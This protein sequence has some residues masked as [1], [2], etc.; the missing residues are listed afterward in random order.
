M[1]GTTTV[2]S[3][4]QAKYNAASK[5]S[6]PWESY[7]ANNLP[8]YTVPLAIFLRRAREL[9]YRKESS[10]HLVQRV[11]RVYSPAV[12]QAMGKHPPPFDVPPGDLASLQGDM[13]SLLEEIYAQHAKKV[14]ELDVFEWF[15]A[16]L[17]GL[18]GQGVVSG[19][20]KALQALVERARV[21]VNWP[22]DFQIAAPKRTKTA[23]KPLH[24]S[25]PE[26]N[27]D[28]TLT[29][30]GRRDMLEGRVKCT[31]E[32]VR[33]Q[34]DP[35]RARVRTYE[36]SLLVYVT[37]WL[38]ERLRERFGFPVNLRFLADYRNLGFLVVVYWFL[39]LVL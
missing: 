21:M 10:I 3:L 18:F 20:E 25:G 33:Y 5:Y 13:Q 29:E 24:T 37:V 35:L 38:S 30:K 7:I 31:A 22:H 19:E 6:A 8:F 23:P 14:G 17:E 36:W 15:G 39:R 27:P 4:P 26:R 2:L 1:V 28:G 9:D 11:F 16:Y 32:T 12:L 34:G